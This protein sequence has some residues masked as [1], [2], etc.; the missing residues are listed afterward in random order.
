MYATLVHGRIVPVKK[1]II[2]VK[3]CQPKM[4]GWCAQL[5][6]CGIPLSVNIGGRVMLVLGTIVDK[7][8]VS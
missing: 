2:Y 7:M 6:G 8:K 3:C 5:M 4:F 1:R